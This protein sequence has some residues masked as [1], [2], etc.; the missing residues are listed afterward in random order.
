MVLTAF[1]TPPA[2]ITASELA[3]AEALLGRW[4]E[5]GAAGAML[6]WYRASAIDVPA[7][8]APL[9]PPEGWRE[10]PF[11]RIACPTLVL[12]GEDDTALPLANTRGL[13]EFVANLTVQCIPDCGHFAPWQAPEVVN[14]ALEAFLA[15]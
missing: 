12:W 11:P 15:G 3:E 8:D 1:G 5:E 13:E 2:R 9:S 14:A 6:N 10:P 7:P 4:Q